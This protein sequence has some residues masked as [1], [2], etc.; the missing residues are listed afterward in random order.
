MSVGAASVTNPQMGEYD[1]IL[2]NSGH[3]VRASTDGI[4]LHRWQNVY[5]DSRK[6]LGV[7]NSSRNSVVGTVSTQWA[8]QWRHCRSIPER[9]KNISPLKPRLNRFCDTP[10]L[11]TMG[12]ERP[13]S[14]YKAGRGVK[15][16]VHF[17]LAT[18]S[19]TH[20]AISP[21]PPPKKKAFV[22]CKKTILPSPFNIG[23]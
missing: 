20:G 9:G 22:A 5:K 19:K 16:T 12:T 13:F 1:L 14:G 7:I 4:H 18:T 11:Y 15:L 10:S 21:S 3:F 17:H 23:L 8:G 6:A 2:S